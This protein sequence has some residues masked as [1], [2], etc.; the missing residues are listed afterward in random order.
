VFSALSGDVEPLTPELGSNFKSFGLELQFFRFK[1]LDHIA[2][3][4]RG[5]I[6]EIWDVYCGI[7][8]V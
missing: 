5:A 1:Y 8:W 4:Y 2:A 3:V 7:A 6:W